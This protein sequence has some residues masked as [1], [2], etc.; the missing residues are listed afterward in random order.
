MLR[1]TNTV[2]FEGVLTTPDVAKKCVHAATSRIILLRVEVVGVFGD[3]DS[4]TIQMVTT[5]DR[6]FKICVII[7]DLYFV[8]G[9]FDL[10]S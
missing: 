7:L 8:R 3:L 4:S 6:N 9:G 2:S 10:T 5:L 1:T